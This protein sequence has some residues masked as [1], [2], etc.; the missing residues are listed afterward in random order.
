ME[1]YRKL[2]DGQ[3]EPFDINPSDLDFFNKKELIK[4]NKINFVGEIITPNDKYF[5]VPKNFPNDINNI[6]LFK[7]VLEKFK[8]EKDEEGKTLLYNKPF[9]LSDDGF[10]KSK[11]Y[12]FEQ[13]KSYFMDYITYEFIYPQDTVKKHSITPIK[14]GRI[15]VMSTDINR[16]IYGSG[17]TYDVKDTVNDDDWK[18]DDIYYYTIFELLQD[19]LQNGYASKKDEKDII[20]MKKY[21]DDEGYVINNYKDETIFSKSDGEKILELFDTK[22]V[23]ESIHNSKINSIHFPIRDILLDYYNERKIK[24]SSFSIKIFYT[25]NFNIVWERL[26]QKCLHD[27]PGFRNDYKKRFKTIQYQTKRFRDIDRYLQFKELL[28]NKNN[29]FIEKENEKE[30]YIKLIFENKSSPDVFSEYPKS[31]GLRFVGDAK[32]YNSADSDFDKEFKTYNRLMDNKYP[33]IV[34]IPG[35]KTY[36]YDKR[37]EVIND[38]EHELLVCYISA[39]DAIDDVINQKD[40]TINVVH[41]IIDKYSDRKYQFN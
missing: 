16:K 15:D 41:Y 10:I 11:K 24:E 8:N 5:S 7:L 21:L 19:G 25:K 3:K 38:E 18:I 4:D 23:I 39:K 26:V 27:S 13:L 31:G 28:K 40:K 34:F 36:L 32:Y 22:S 20:D 33:M 12:Y 14:G 30:L 1:N 35:D 6:E 37:Q 9:V 2:R 29:V 17:I